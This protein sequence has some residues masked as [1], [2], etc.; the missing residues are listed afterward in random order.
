MLDVCLTYAISPDELCFYFAQRPPPQK[1]PY[2]NLQQN[3]SCILGYMAAKL[4]YV[5]DFYL[6]YFLQ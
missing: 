2:N 6:V 3:T 1:S 5:T 4:V